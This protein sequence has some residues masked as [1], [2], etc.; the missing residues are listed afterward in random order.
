MFVTTQ[1][2]VFRSYPFKDNRYITKVFTSEEGLL[3]FIVKKTKNQVILSQ[4]FTIAEITYK[5]QK[6]SSLFHV[7]DVHVDYVYRDLLFN[8]EKLQLVIILSEILQKCLNA[9]NVTIRRDQALIK[10]FF[11]RNFHWCVLKHM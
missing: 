1:G 5:K 6:H 9:K 10:V 3:S 4:P 8:N 2:I 11:G 7:K